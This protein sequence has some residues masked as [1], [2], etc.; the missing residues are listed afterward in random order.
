MTLS[1]ITLK[2]TTKLELLLADWQFMHQNATTLTGIMMNVI[3]P[4]VILL[5]VT[6]H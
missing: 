1:R 6:A 2:R 5:R 3:L 4:N